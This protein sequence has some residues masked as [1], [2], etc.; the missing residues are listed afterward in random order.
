MQTFS[1]IKSVIFDYGGT[2][3]TPARH[4]ASVIFE[5]YK[6]AA[7][8]VSNDEFR[9]AYV[10]GER[11]LAKAPII[12]PS[13]DFKA[14]MLKKVREEFSDL[15]QRGVWNPE[16]AERERLIEAVASY[17]DDY[18]R[19]TT[20]RSCDVLKTLSGKYKLVLVS[21]FYGNIHAVLSS[22]GLLPFFSEVVESAVVGVRKPDPAIYRLGVESAGCKPSE[23]VVVGDSF[24]KDIVPAKAVGCK[25]VW[26]KGEE[27][28]PEAHDESLPD[29][30]ITS[31]SQL[32][33][34]L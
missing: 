28:K 25:A 12:C 1:D 34:L 18:A 27:W 19:N 31:L 8:P 6:H 26:L 16:P 7:V 13:D 11:A 5:A 23:A 14:V 10:Y 20:A 22:Y 32:P 21:N 15:S 17:C 2:L 29:A 30:I 24:G 33:P 3:D 9:T 4:W